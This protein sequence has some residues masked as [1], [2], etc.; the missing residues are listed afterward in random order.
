MIPIVGLFAILA[1]VLALPFLVKKVEENL[2]LFL[3]AAG[4]AAVSVSGL[5]SWELVGEALLEPVK[6][7]AAVLVAGF[8]FLL[9]GRPIRAAVG[10]ATRALGLRL[11]AFAVV[12]LLGLLSS[13]ITAIIAALVLVEIVTALS[14]DRESEL[15]LV[16]VACFS[17]GMG[18]A[19]TPLGEPLTTIAI[20]KLKGEPYNAGFWFCLKL[21]GPYVLPGVLAFGALAAALIGRGATA[22]ALPAE[23]SLKE[24]REEGP[25]DVLLRCAKTYL[26]VT[27]LVL[28]GSGF[29]PL[30]DAYVSRIPSAGL[31][32]LNSISAI[33]DNAT[34]TAAEI[35]PSMSR[36]QIG[37]ALLGLIV[38][39][40]ILIPGNIPNII[41]AGKLKIRSGEWARIG[42]PIGLAAMAIYFVLILA[43]GI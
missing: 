26:F 8:L 2:E 22:S 7:S 25:L 40:G 29:K 43:I 23:A 41:S 36:A 27:A 6:I 17:I 39:G 32:W 24:D 35:G 16:V 15:K 5:W 31:F 21:L 33:L 42:A 20:G 19:L 1:A 37:S 4:A 12:V 9:A 30:I 13:V 3:F 34:L 11:F 38:S 10:A 14:L 28:L 18:A